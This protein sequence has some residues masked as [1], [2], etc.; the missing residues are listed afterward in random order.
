MV[1]ERLVRENRGGAGPF[2]SSNEIKV[3]RKKKK[4][5]DRTR[6]TVNRCVFTRYIP[7]G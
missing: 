5:S 2:L 7:C 3:E 4:A 6:L 1:S